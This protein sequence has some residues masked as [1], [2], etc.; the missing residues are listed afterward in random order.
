AAS[1]PPAERLRFCG[2]LEDYNFH[3]YFWLL[4]SLASSHPLDIEVTGHADDRLPVEESLRQYFARLTA[5]RAVLNFT[6][7][8]DGQRM[9]V[10]RSSDA[11]CAGR[12]LVQE[13]A[14]DMR[15]YF[16]PGAHY[17][18]FRDRDELGAIAARLAAPGAY[19][20]VRCAGA[21]HF[22]ATYSNL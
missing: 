2:A 3:R 17:L 15:C 1:P 19:E 6:M 20:D 22:A 4:S 16:E 11:L 5:S 18:E 13:Y 8:A 14:D 10:G 12:L 21:A 9:M 7:R